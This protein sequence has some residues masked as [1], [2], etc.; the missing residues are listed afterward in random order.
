MFH[1]SA[2]LTAVKGVVDKCPKDPESS[3]DTIQG[4][5]SPSPTPAGGTAAHGPAEPHVKGMTAILGNPM[6]SGVLIM[7]T[8]ALPADIAEWRAGLL[9]PSDLKSHDEIVRE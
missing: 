9:I 6:S 3:K 8:E 5:P 1:V 7:K 2:S 4:K